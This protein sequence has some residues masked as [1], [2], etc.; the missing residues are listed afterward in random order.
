[1][2]LLVVNQLTYGYRFEE[3]EEIINFTENDMKNFNDLG[4]LIL[5]I[6]LIHASCFILL[7]II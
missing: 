1:M 3:E 5:G 2:I 4:W 7:E 6:I